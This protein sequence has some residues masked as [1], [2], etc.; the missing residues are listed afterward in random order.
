MMGP[1]C[2]TTQAV[3]HPR[4]VQQGPSESSAACSH[5]RVQ[6]KPTTQACAKH[7]NLLHVTDVSI[8]KSCTAEVQSQCLA[9]PPLLCAPPT[10]AQLPLPPPVGFTGLRQYKLKAC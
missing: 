5:Q 2:C 3:K 9:S 10:S 8:G 6:P 7:T 4:Y 1:I